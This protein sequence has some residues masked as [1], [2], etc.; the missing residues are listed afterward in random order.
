MKSH[1]LPANCGA[2]QLEGE[3]RNTSV[4][5]GFFFFWFQ[6]LVIS[7]KD[8]STLWSVR[9]DNYTLSPGLS[10][11]T[12]TDE[13]SVFVVRMVGVAARTCCLQSLLDSPLQVSTVSVFVHTFY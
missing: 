10:L 7:G 11:K 4:Y 3:Q 1:S 8:G 5:M 6:T 13:F 12:A 2:V 9:T